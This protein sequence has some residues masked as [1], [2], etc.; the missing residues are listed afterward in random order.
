MI[1]KFAGGWRAMFRT[2][3]GLET[4]DDWVN[5]LES[6][7]HLVDEYGEG[8]DAA[9]FVS[10]CVLRSDLRSHADEYEGVHEKYADM[11]PGEWW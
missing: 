3:P 5:H 2:Y 6:I 7:G 4:W 8:I 10:R 9:E 11:C 1:A